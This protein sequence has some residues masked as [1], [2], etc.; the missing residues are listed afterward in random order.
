MTKEDFDK[1]SEDEKS[2]MQIGANSLKRIINEM[3]KC[4]ATDDGGLIFKTIDAKS[5]RQRYFTL[6]GYEENS[7]EKHDV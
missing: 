6:T 3:I 5:G 2:M 7:P 4:E 1:L